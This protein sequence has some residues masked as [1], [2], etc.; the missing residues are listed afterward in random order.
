MG[1]YLPHAHRLNSGLKDL[2]TVYIGETTFLHGGAF[3][4]RGMRP[5]FSGGIIL[6][7]KSPGHNINVYFVPEIGGNYMYKQP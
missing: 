6:L 5:Y 2:G 1:V 3:E 4:E 7:T